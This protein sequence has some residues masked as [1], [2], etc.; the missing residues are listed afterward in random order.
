MT[1][2]ETYEKIS[3]FTLVTPDRC[4]ALWNL[5]RQAAALPGL[6]AEVGVYRG[7]TS[8]LLALACPEKKVH[9]F[10]TFT[11]IPNGDPD[12]DHH[13]KGDFDDVGVE[14]F[15]RLRSTGVVIHPGLFPDTVMDLNSSTQ[16]CFAHFDGDTY[17]SCKAFLR[18]FWPRLVEGGILVFDDY[19]WKHCRGVEKALEEHGI[20]V[21]ESAAYQCFIVRGFQSKPEAAFHSGDLGDI[22]YSLPAI[23]A[24]GLKHL[25]IN[26]KGGAGTAHVMT[27]ERFRMIEPLLAEQPYIESVT[28]GT[29]AESYVN[30][31]GFRYHSD[32]SN[33]WLPYLYTDVLSLDRACAST[34]WI[35]P[36]PLF[37]SPVIFA[38][39]ARYHNPHFPWGRVIEKYGRYATFIGT[40]EEHAAL[41]AEYRYSCIP[42]YETR[43]LEDAAQV[44]AG[45]QLFIGNQSC[46]LAIAE[47]LKKRI[48][49][50]VCPYCPNCNSPRPDFTPG[51]DEQVELPNLELI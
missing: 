50:E 36:D 20:P 7:G 22:I 47:G 43:T 11:G 16:Y 40:P 30:L 21:I 14:V 31:D 17:E 41:N 9:A 18:Y 2:Q 32:T 12:I 39:S 19:K 3:P 23:R 24:M 6:V 1:F 4:H 13:K 48:V 38:R 10:D 5:S 28:Y 46:P 45:A 27:P 8:M 15:D 26:D 51:V 35:Q 34:A 49:A 37:V 44:I 33:T 29:P 25:Y 42:F